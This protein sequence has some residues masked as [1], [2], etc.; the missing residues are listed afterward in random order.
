ML[1]RMVIIDVPLP[2]AEAVC[3]GEA[4]AGTVVA[5]DKLRIFGHSSQHVVEI[6]RMFARHKTYEEEFSPMP[7]SVPA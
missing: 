2:V 5:F 3:L 1:T 7:E 6:Q 4:V